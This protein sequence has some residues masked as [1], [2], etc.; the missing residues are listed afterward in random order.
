MDG[1]TVIRA[2]GMGISKLLTKLVFLKQFCDLDR[3]QNRTLIISILGSH[4]EA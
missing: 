1:S 2:I 4:N 3:L